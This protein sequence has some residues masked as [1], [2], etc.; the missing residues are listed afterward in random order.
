MS[1]RREYAL[2]AIE[3]QIEVLRE[4]N[5]QN[6][7]CEV[8]IKISGMICHLANTALAHTPESFSRG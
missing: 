6:L 2:E 1:K 3:E 4:L 7:D 5:K 8:K